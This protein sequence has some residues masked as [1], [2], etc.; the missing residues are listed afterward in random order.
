MT[1]TQED[2]SATIAG[3]MIPSA[4]ETCFKNGKCSSVNRTTSFHAMK[5]PVVLGHDDVPGYSEPPVDTTTPATKSIMKLK[6]EPN[7]LKFFSRW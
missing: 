1:S 7:D 5:G 2:A 4:P 6:G 3:M